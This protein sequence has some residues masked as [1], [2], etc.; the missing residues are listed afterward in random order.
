MSINYTGNL[1]V[2]ERKLKFP[3][4]MK[5]PYGVG[6]NMD[7]APCCTNTYIS[8]TPNTMNMFKPFSEPRCTPETENQEIK[9]EIN[10]LY[11]RNSSRTELTGGAISLLH[12]VEAN[13]KHLN[14]SDKRELKQL[15]NS[16]IDIL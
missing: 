6:I 10:K 5:Q 7:Q 3:V 12:N 8:A 9:S 4:A 2:N 16:I 13:H 1:K 15:L 14:P 11:A